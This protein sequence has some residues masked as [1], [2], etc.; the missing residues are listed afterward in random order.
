M[1]CSPSRPL[2]GSRRRPLFR[3]KSFNCL[4]MFRIQSI[5][6]NSTQSKS[7]K[8]RNRCDRFT[9]GSPGTKSRHGREKPVYEILRYSDNERL[10]PNKAI[11]AVKIGAVG[12][13]H[14]DRLAGIEGFTRAAQGG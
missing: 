1:S 3:M 12:I 6:H 4:S 8:T 5:T 9:V 11:D 14:H 10:V 13:G 2:A 7:A